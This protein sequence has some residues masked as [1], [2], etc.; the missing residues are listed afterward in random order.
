MVES[1]FHLKTTD[2]HREYEHV[3]G[4]CWRETVEYRIHVGDQEAQIWIFGRE[5]K[6]SHIAGCF[7]STAIIT[8]QPKEQRVLVLSNAVLL[9]EA[10]SSTHRLREK[11]LSSQDMTVTR[12]CSKAERSWIFEEK[13][14]RRF[15]AHFHVG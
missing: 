6:K 12:K 13:E 3:C 11:R 4:C 15:W 2:G 1:N 7:R 10:T 9:C 5:K 8:T 14:T